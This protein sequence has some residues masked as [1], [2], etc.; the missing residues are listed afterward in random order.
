MATVQYFSDLS[1]GGVE[2]MFG[3]FEEHAF[4]LHEHDEYMFGIVERGSLD[5]TCGGRRQNIGPGCVVVLNPGDPH[6]GKS[7]PD[8]W[9]C[10]DIRIRP[11][12]VCSILGLDLAPKLSRNIVHCDRLRMEIATVYDALANTHDLMTRESAVARLVAEFAASLA[13]ERSAAAA[14]G[15]RGKIAQLRDVID[16]QFASDVSISELSAQV[17]LNPNYAITAFKEEFGITPRKYLISRRLEC[18]KSLIREGASLAQ[19]AAAVG[20]FDQSHL[21]RAFRSEF[22]YAPST[23]KRAHKKRR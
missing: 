6:T 12:T 5:L 19:A 23:F 2:Y 13:G 3:D 15:R 9:A 17:G 16:A 21:T 14:N 18:A 22:G 8:G 20:F 1:Y 11:E 10:R 4:G 7:G